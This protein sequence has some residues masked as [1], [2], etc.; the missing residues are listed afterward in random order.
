M[1][2]VS[3]K[4]AKPKDLKV[5]CCHSIPPLVITPSFLPHVRNVCNVADASSDNE[6]WR[7]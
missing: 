6:Q 2:T 3:K 7:P 1:S 4:E 5:C